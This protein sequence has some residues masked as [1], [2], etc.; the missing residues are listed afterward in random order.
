MVT[1]PPPR[2]LLLLYGITA[3][4]ALPVGSTMFSTLN[5]EAGQ[6]LAP[7]QM[8]DGF[9]YTVFSDFWAE[10]ERAVRPV[11]RMGWLTG[12]ILHSFRPTG[13]QPFRATAFW[14]VSTH[15]VARYVRLLGVTVLFTLGVF[16][17]PFLIGLLLAIALEDSLTEPGLF[18]LGFGG[19]AVGVLGTLLIWC[20]A[21]YAKAL[22]YRTDQHGA[23]RAYGQAG[24]FV[25]AHLRA[26]FG[27]YLLLVALGAA[28]LGTYLL[29]D[30]L[31][32]MRNWP[33]ILL[34]FALQQVIILGRVVLKVL[35][36]R[37]AYEVGAKIFS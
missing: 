14:Q 21:D 33:L 3:L 11:L 27:R 32:P 22:M 35:T 30:S 15:Y 5:T 28:L 17:V 20:I 6:S 9:N 13:G 16:L 37:V 18:W 10:S 1:L 34:L 12:G 19:F 25:L 31:I 2:L 4:L 24:R 8:L 36:L 26:T 23:F 29:L 7:L